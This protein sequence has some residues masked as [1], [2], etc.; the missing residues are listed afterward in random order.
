MDTE[1]QSHPIL[2]ACSIKQEH[3]QNDISEL[4][5]NHNSS[6]DNNLNNT[7]STESD[8]GNQSGQTPLSTMAQL[9]IQSADLVTSDSHEED[10]KPS[11]KQIESCL[12]EELLEIE[13]DTDFWE[14]LTLRIRDQVVISDP[15]SSRVLVDGRRNKINIFLGLEDGIVI[16]GQSEGVDQ[17]TT[18]AEQLQCETLELSDELLNSAPDSYR[19]PRNS[20]E[21]MQLLYY[22]TN[23]YLNEVSWPQEYLLKRSD[24]EQKRFSYD[25]FDDYLRNQ[26]LSLLAMFHTKLSK[27]NLVYKKSK[28]YHK[29]PKNSTDVKIF[30][31]FVRYQCDDEDSLDDWSTIELEI[32][33]SGDIP[34][35]GQCVCLITSAG[36]RPAHQKYFG[37]VIESRKVVE[38]YKSCSIISVRLLESNFSS[39]EEVEIVELFSII[40]I[41]LSIDGI[42]KLSSM[43]WAKHVIKPTL[44]S[45]SSGIPMSCDER[46]FQQWDLDCIQKALDTLT[47]SHPDISPY[48]CLDFRE[49]TINHDDYL[50]IPIEILRQIRQNEA[51]IY[52]N[53]KSSSS[54]SDTHLAAPKKFQTL[55]VG[56]DENDLSHIEKRL[57]DDNFSTFNVAKPPRKEDENLLCI[58]KKLSTALTVLDDFEDCE[59]IV[60]ML[61][62]W[63][64][65]CKGRFRSSEMQCKFNELLDFAR[66]FLLR[67]AD[68]VIGNLTVL[69]NNQ[70]I[71][72]SGCKLSSCIVMESE[73]ITEPILWS[74]LR[75][76]CERFVFFSKKK[77]DLWPRNKSIFNRMLAAYTDEKMPF[78]GGKCCIVTNTK[79]QTF[80]PP[81]PAG[82]RHN[83]TKSNY[84][85]RRPSG[86][87]DY[88]PEQRKNPRYTPYCP[89]PNRN[90]R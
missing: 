6:S 32:D 39:E 88:H 49:K 23:N 82:S 87:S 14:E 73:S 77:V 38:N 1:V 60:E 65:L 16:D 81:P 72:S 78:K 12:E 35:Y 67:N 33:K 83:R 90:E 51:F 44:L 3:H 54:E 36:H 31:G 20:D 63:D 11:V 41:Y 53:S 43:P 2:D 29:D 22:W 24:C 9:S 25:S 13:E 21:F 18:N 46:K 40:H 66:I 59:L 5:V 84:R 50:R 19:L 69:C 10:I 34:K 28:Q 75:F 70:I 17:A 26:M 89:R 74:L 56:I 27:A 57:K 15:I 71:L 7:L 61:Q 79:K 47:L 8:D 80:V 4:N 42:L 55:I 48:C 68:V 45:S 37:T 64:N 76:G 52:S 85:S 62:E 86:P 58:C 30:T